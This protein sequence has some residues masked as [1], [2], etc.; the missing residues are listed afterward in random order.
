MS[1]HVIHE[2]LNIHITD[3]TGASRRH[4]SGVS[5]KLF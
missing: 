3:T 4:P 2:R 5:D 1:I